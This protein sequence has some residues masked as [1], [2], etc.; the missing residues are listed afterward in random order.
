MFTIKIKN[1]DTIIRNLADFDRFNKRALSSAMNRSH[2]AGVK[3]ATSKQ[4]GGTLQPWGIKK[5]DFKR[6]Y[7]WKQKATSRKPNTKY[8]VSSNPINLVDFGAKWNRLTPQGKPTKGISY[9]LKNRRRTMKG[10][11]IAKGMFF[12]RKQG[13]QNI[14][15]HFSI[16]P[17]S[18][19]VGNE[20]VNTYVEKYFDVL[21]PRYLHELDR[22][23]KK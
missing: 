10:S 1:I 5:S 21:N 17:T 20:G 18:M 22:L 7:T 2:T 14:I 3:V 8:A 13:T 23:I 16:T 4:T 6:N 12:T 11:F 15:P 9:K 19:F